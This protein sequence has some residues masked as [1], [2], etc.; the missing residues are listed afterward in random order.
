MRSMKQKLYSLILAGTALF[1]FANT[2][3][4]TKKGLFIDTTLRSGKLKNGLSYYIKPNR[5]RPKQ[6]SFYFVQNVGSV[7][8][9]EDQ[10]GLAHFLEHM[11]F[12]GSKNFPEASMLGYLKKYGLNFG[13]D[14]N[15]L[16]SYDHMMYNISNVPLSVPRLT[17][18]VL[19]IMHDW[20][21]YLTLTDKELDKERG[22]IKEEWRMLNTPESRSSKTV[23]REALVKGSRYEHRDP[24]G[25]M[26]VVDN[27]RPQKLRQFYKTWYRPDLQA[28]VIV[29][30]VDT[31]TIEQKIISTFSSIPT[32]TGQIRRPEFSVPYRNNFRYATGLDKEQQ[33]TWIH[34]YFRLTPPQALNASEEMTRSAFIKII[35]ERMADLAAGP[36]AAVSEVKCAYTPIVRGMDALSFTIS[37][38]SDD[39]IRA[40]DFT[41]NE[42][43]RFSRY[44]ATPS[45]LARAKTALNNT[46][47]QT[48]KMAD[49]MD[50]DSYAKKIADMFL[51]GR[52]LTN[53][54][55]YWK[56]LLPVINGL[57]NTHLLSYLHKTLNYR[58][59]MVGITGNTALHTPAKDQIL[60]LISKDRSELPDYHS[61]YTDKPLIEEQLAETKIRGTFSLPDSNARG[62]V[63]QNGARVILYPT[64]LRPNV[65]KFNA[66]SQ[67][68]NSL[69]QP[70]GQRSASLAMAVTA[71]SGLGSFNLRELSKKL[72]GTRST[73]YP[74]V[75]DYTESLSGTTLSKDLEVL[76]KR[77][78][79]TFE[80][81]RFEQS[82]YT[83]LAG[84]YI[85]TDNKTFDTPQQEFSDTMR[86]VSNSSR[87]PRV[88]PADPVPPS[89]EEM[90]QAYHARFGNAAD[91]TFCFTGDIDSLS[92]LPLITRYLGNIKSTDVREKAIDRNE[93]FP[94]GKTQISLS[95]PMEVPQSTVQISLSKKTE[96][97]LQNT[98]SLK[99]LA[100]LLQARYLKLIR[101]DAGATYT[102]SVNARPSFY[103]DQQFRLIIYFN[104]SPEKT[105]KLL[106]IVYTEL[107]HIKTNV[108]A[109][110]LQETK[111]LLK[112]EFENSEKSIT[113]ISDALVNTAVFGVALPSAEEYSELIDSLSEKDLL[114][115][116]KRYLNNADLIE[117]I[118]SPQTK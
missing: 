93:G 21:A 104:C 2:T 17:D 67:G 55:A 77:I 118:L 90:R 96:Y 41:I 65:I 115:F 4:Q 1:C 36:D 61:N 40:L 76:L 105:E 83:Q 106:K 70:R 97:I 24:I 103:P 35:N 74:L 68:G 111:A 11:A 113:D 30:D 59:A 14:I 56:T 50:N 75:N 44:G 116:F 101:E 60:Q 82:I 73:L 94:A 85:E 57:A 95:R 20:S 72:T 71:Q 64:K 33:K 84:R 63:L 16:T 78:Y 87:T 15:A 51:T 38:A 10:R 92:A 18:S 3:G 6:A 58:D 102:V 29:G 100:R 53:Y 5:V 47:S 112:H 48:A 28:I 88:G 81:P 110:E 99:M 114:K 46:Y 26:S 62:Y 45:E 43:S 34:L 13:T 109:L 117:G 37:P 98:V 19:L 42:L 89:F 9:R 27:S 22:V 86:V 25:L 91:F 12:N 54:K 66:A 52:P 8:E 7:L 31:K 39:L 32:A 108:T 23:Y 79:L 107:E 80:H 49:G 69:L